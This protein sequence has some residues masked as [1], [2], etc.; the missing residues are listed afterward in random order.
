M[1]EDDAGRGNET[2]VKRMNV[3]KS[4][5]KSNNSEKENIKKERLTL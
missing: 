2:T 1:S 5:C 3:T 4:R